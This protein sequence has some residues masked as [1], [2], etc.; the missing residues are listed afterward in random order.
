MSKVIIVSRYFPTYHNRSGEETFFVE[1]I[2]ESLGIVPEDNPLLC[3][4]DFDLINEYEPKHHTIR[5]GNRWKVGD[6]ASLRVWSGKPRRS[7]QIIIAPDVEIKKIWSFV[8]TGQYFYLNDK[9][10]DVTSSDV[11]RNDGLSSDDFLGWFP[12]SNSFEGQVLSWNG[13]I[14]Y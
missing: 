5:A 2:W 14:E 13:D 8:C 11:P 6:K 9:Q 1:K 3:E 12:E 10:I 7:K 4:S